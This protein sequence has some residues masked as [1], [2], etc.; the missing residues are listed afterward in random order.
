MAAEGGCGW[1]GGQERRR[2]WRWMRAVGRVAAAEMDAWSRKEGRPLT[3]L[4]ALPSV[5]TQA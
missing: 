4:K 1:R 5:N 3:W 2:R